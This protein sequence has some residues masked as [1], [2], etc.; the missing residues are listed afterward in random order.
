MSLNQ[1]IFALAW[2][3]ILSNISV[4]LLGLVDTAVLGHLSSADYLAAVALG[5]SLFSFL[6]WGF[7]FLRMGT[8]GVVAQA[9]GQQH[10]AQVI[11]L[12]QQ[13]IVLALAVASVLLLAQT[14]LIE[15]GLVL[16]TDDQGLQQLAGQ[17][18][19]VRI[20][21]APAVLINYVL[22]GWFLAQQNSRF[23][24]YMLVL[25]NSVNIVLDLWFV[26][27]LG[28]GVPGVAM[29]TLIAEVSGMAFGLWLVRDGL[30]IAG[31]R[32][33]DAVRLKR[34]ATVNGHIMIRSVLLQGCFTAF[35][36]L[37]SGRGDLVIAA[38]QI[39]LQFLELMAYLLDGFA[40][41]AE[42]LVGQA[43]GARSR[44]RL[45]RAVRM[46][47]IWGGAGALLMAGLF[48][49]AGP[50]IIDLM[51]TAGDVRAEARHYLPWIVA[52]PLVAIAA[53]ML[54]GIF[55]G[56][57]FTREM[58]LSAALSA[59]TYVLCVWAFL[60]YGNHGLW[61]SL[62]VFNAARGLSLAALYP[63]IPRSLNPLPL[64]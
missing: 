54:D 38:N 61:L 15:W 60:G 59:A 8:T 24:F 37:S 34:M 48:A 3:I 44:E 36:F 22:L 19:G 31:A 17:Y 5:A 14:W 1:K 32:V 25:G 23:S 9:A 30:R 43:V 18:A 41:A 50:A 58:M 20:W 7:G 27:G 55:I 2:P 64:A 63:K 56:A 4:P 28:W 51:T 57:T 13:G 11:Q 33:F 29:A 12:L 47:S 35:L 40:F 52:A 10:W 6:F 16:L 62:M 46:T 49:L 26:L 21:A 45:A 53:W 39:L 42:T